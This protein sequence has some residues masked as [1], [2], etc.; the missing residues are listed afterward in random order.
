MWDYHGQQLTRFTA[1][2]KIQT[3]GFLFFRQWRETSVR[4]N[5]AVSTSGG[6]R[7]DLKSI[8]LTLSNTHKKSVLCLPQKST[9]VW[10]WTCRAQR[11]K[12]PLLTSVRRALMFLPPFPITA[13]AFWNYG[14]SDR[15]LSKNTSV[16]KEYGQL[17]DILPDPSVRVLTLL[18]NSTRSSTMSSDFRERLY[19]GSSSMSCAGR[20]PGIHKYKLH[21]AQH[22]S[23]SNKGE[24]LCVAPKV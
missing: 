13:P 20:L 4:G 3:A 14:V 8:I 5:R 17:S 1:L 2:R 10:L 11:M 22:I 15:Q 7:L 16:V 9:Y 21:W 18:C 12:S 23:T 24:R 19:V 6:W